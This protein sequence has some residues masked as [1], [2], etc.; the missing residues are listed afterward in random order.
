MA[1]KHIPDGYHAVTPYL[2]VEGA[3]RLIEFMKDVFG[4][5]ERMRMPG[6]NGV[7]GHAEMEI[8]DSVVMLADSASADNNIVMPAMINLYVEDCDGA[9]KKALAAGATSDRE[10]S[11]QFYGDR[12]AGVVDPF[13][14]RWFIATHVEDVSPEEMQR[15]SAELMKRQGQA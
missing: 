7:V 10:P 3:D 4:A 8:G 15:R 6:P 14:N 12:N 13:G 5:T 11:D 9:Y 1:V 2:V